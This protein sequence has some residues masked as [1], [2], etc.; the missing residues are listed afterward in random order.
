METTLRNHHKHVIAEPYSRAGLRFTKFLLLP[1]VDD[2]CSVFA[3]FI[4]KESP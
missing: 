1:N 2:F 3:I 4:R